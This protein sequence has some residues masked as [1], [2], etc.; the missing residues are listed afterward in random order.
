MR[1][2]LKNRTFLA[3]FFIFKRYLYLKIDSFPGTL[4]AKLEYIRDWQK[5]I[6]NPKDQKVI[7]KYSK[8]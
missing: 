5:S 4:Y 6:F 8:Y 3:I 1:V 2:I 7:A